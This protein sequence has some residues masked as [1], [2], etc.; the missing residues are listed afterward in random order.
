MKI[1]MIDRP[2]TIDHLPALADAIAALA[3]SLSNKP[4]RQP[5]EYE[6]VVKLLH[7]HRELHQTALIL[8]AKRKR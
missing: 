7:V 8:G 2:I 3:L 1:Q 6:C 4:D 5:R